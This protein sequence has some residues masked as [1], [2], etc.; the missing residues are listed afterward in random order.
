M[1]RCGLETGNGIPCRNFPSTI[2]AAAHKF[3]GNRET[4][5]RSVSELFKEVRA[6]SPNL[7]PAEKLSEIFDE[8]EK[9]ND[10]RPGDSNEERGFDTVHE[11]HKK[12]DHT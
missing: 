11:K 4:Q 5:P 1:Q 2:N 12:M 8:A 7:V 10:R 9:D 6:G 3:G